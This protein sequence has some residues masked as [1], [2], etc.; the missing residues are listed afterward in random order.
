MHHLWTQSSQSVATG[1]PSGAVPVRGKH[2]GAAKRNAGSGRSISPR[3]RHRSVRTR[4]K[5]KPNELARPSRSTSEFP[6]WWG[7]GCASPCQVAKKRVDQRRFSK[8]AVESRGFPT[9]R[10][11]LLVATWLGHASAFTILNPTLS[12]RK[13]NGRS[14]RKSSVRSGRK[15]RRNVPMRSRPRSRHGCG[16]HCWVYR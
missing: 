6:S 5:L 4:P 15:Q 12:P 2:R 14:A 7:V 9:V 8:N 16:H 10:P 3:M 13:K 11:Q 1:V